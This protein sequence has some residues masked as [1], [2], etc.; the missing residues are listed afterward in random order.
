MSGLGPPLPILVG[1][2]SDT[3]STDCFA[4]HYFAILD[5]TPVPVPLP[6]NNRQ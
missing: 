1:Y 3:L 2:E 6:A 4:G 5:A